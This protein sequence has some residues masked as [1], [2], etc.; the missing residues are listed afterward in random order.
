MV[1][2]EEPWLLGDPGAF[3]ALDAAAPA[4]S[5]DQRQ[6]RVTEQAVEVLHGEYLL[7]PLQVRRLHGITL[8]NPLLVHVFQSVVRVHTSPCVTS[9][10]HGRRL[11]R[12]RTAILVDNASCGTQSV[13]VA[14]FSMPISSSLLWRIFAPGADRQLAREDS[15]LHLIWL[16]AKM[17]MVEAL[18]KLLFACSLNVAAPVAEAAKSRRNARRDVRLGEEH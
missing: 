17:R 14:S 8:G 6:L 2:C 1:R 9:P 12:A 10:A 11:R 13:S 15:C 18:Q 5:V 4:R 16:I 3:D 7:H